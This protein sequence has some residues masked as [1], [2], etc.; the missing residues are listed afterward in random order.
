MALDKKDKGYILTS[1]LLV[2]GI[3]FTIL[4]WDL[5]FTNPIYHIKAIYVI[6]LVAAY[7]CGIYFTYAKK[8]RK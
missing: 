1:S 6:I 3:I 4:K 8:D 5:K 7:S 2:L